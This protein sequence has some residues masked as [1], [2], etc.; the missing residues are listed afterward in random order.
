[1]VYSYWLQT[2]YAG[3]YM[4][5]TSYLGYAF[6]MGTLVWKVSQILFVLNCC[7]SYPRFFSTQLSGNVLMEL[8]WWNKWRWQVLWRYSSYIARLSIKHDTPT[9]L[10]SSIHHLLHNPFIILLL[11]DLFQLRGWP[12]MIWGRAGGN[13]EKI[14]FGGPSPGKTMSF[15]RSSI[16]RK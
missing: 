13:Q 6:A 4:F 15:N 11:E 10:Q 3:T 5:Y 7:Y 8:N 2:R 1:M 12:L 14:I 16:I 9:Q